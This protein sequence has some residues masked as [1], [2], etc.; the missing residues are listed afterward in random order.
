LDYNPIEMATRS[1]LERFYRLWNSEY[2]R[3]LSGYIYDE[4]G[5]PNPTRKIFLYFANVIERFLN[6]EIEDV[7]KIHLLYGLR[8]IGK[9]TLLGQI[10]YAPKFI[11]A[12][13]RADF[14][15]LLKQD[16][17]RLFLDV[18]VL[19]LEGISL[20]EF[21]KFY[22][23]INAFNFVRPK[24]KLIFL[25][26]EVHYDVDWGTFLKV[27]FDIT[28]GHRNLLIIA[29]GSSA[30][31]LKMNPDL[32]R[33]SLSIELY[34]LSFKEYT[35]LKGWG[36]VDDGLSKAV[37]DVILFAQN[38]SEIFNVIKDFMQDINNYFLNLPVGIEEEFFY[39]GGFPFILRLSNNK[40]LIYELVSGVIDKLLIKDILE[41]RGFRSETLSKIKDLLYLLASSDQSDFQKLSTTLKLDYRSLRAILDAL[42]LSGLVFEVRSY[43]GKFRRVRKPSKFL[44]TTPTLRTS[45]LNGVVP[46]EVKGKILEDYLALIFISEFSNKILGGNPLEV[47][48]DSSSGGADFILRLGDKKIIVEV[49]YGEKREGIK[50]IK[51]TGKNIGDFA[52]GIL[53]SAEDEEIE[54]IEEKIVKIPLKVFLVI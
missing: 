12:S 51:T 27:M 29:T 45:I 14:P 17:Q 40:P 13:L 43:G 35:L 11:P 34:P 39:Y 21:F 47:M 25:L 4:E 6:D 24:K 54:L 49:G 26:D 38:A 46:T 18:S 53:L 20:N 23:E 19:S 41:I 52:Y 7:E 33:R 22:Q 30:L 16:Y 44:F 28:K 32:S 37:S 5:N 10:L 50:Q 15:Q 31:K 2:E 48:Y 1:D 8:G 42:I 3:I 9:T 36:T